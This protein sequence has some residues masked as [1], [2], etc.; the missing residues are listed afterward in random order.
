VFT[1]S[2]DGSR[3]QEALRPRRQ[4]H[5]ALP[6]IEPP[7]LLEPAALDVLRTDLGVPAGRTV[8]GISGRLVRWKHQDAVLEATALLHRDGRDVHALIVGGE[9]HGHDAGY[10]DELE[11]L[12]E[13]LGIADRVTFTGHR[14][15]PVA[16]T[17]LMDVAVNASDPEPFGLVVLEALAV[18]RPVVAVARGGPA[19][20]VEDGVT[21]TLVPAPAPRDLA[22]ALAPL[23]DDPEARERMG[24]AGREAVLSRFSL[25]RFA[26]GVREGLDRYVN[27]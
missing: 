6:G 13:S 21:G 3:A 22:T 25:D 4:V 10:G 20:I 9:G 24:A 15:D 19:V 5:L 11:R 16:L 17:Q 8:I 23:V 26:A 7:E 18:E 1:C 12:A 27:R 2:P 14:D